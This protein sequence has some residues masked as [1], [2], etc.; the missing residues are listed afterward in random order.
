MS[1]ANTTLIA[2]QHEALTIESDFIR[3]VDLTQNKANSTTI[4][5]IYNKA[6]I[7]HGMPMP[8]PNTNFSSVR[9]SYNI[10]SFVRFHIEIAK[11]YHV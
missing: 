3:R 2:A 11:I 9:P 10:V 1:D 4:L 6:D 5:L 7:L 8:S